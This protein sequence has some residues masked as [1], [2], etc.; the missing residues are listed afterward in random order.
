MEKLYTISQDSKS[1]AWYCH[2]K[3]YPNIPVFGS[4]GDKKKAQEIC[5]I[6]NNRGK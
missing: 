1:G 5:R 3:G 4:I 6:R 2:K